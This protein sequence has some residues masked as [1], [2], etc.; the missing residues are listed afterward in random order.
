MF[1]ILS[2]IFGAGT[3]GGVIDA[4]F[5]GTGFAMPRFVVVAGSEVFIPG[6]LGNAFIG[7]IAALISFG[8]Y[9]PFSSAPLIRTKD[10]NQS[11]SDAPLA[12]QLTL[13]TLAGALLVGYSGG[14]WINAEASKQLNHGT[15]VAVAQTAERLAASHQTRALLRNTPSEAE[16]KTFTQS[17]Q[18]AT[19]LES[20][21]AALQ[22]LKGDD[23]TSK[24]S[25]TH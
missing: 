6:F 17:I 5:N 8:L 9:G 18:T 13:A 10:P 2:L 21:H 7:G 19:P 3:I 24:S 14:R 4:L 23:G 16:M 12:S 25:E 11:N 22:L 1:K 20:Y 15:A